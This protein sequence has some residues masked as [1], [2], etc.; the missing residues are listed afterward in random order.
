MGSLGGA[1]SDG[2]E[3][4][5]SSG[6]S[7]IFGCGGAGFL[8]TI[9]ARLICFARGACRRRCGAVAGLGFCGR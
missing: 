4:T 2:F 6:D 8:S 1:G 7:T 5:V 9:G 3:E